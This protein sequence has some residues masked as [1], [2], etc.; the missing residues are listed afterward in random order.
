M[1]KIMVALIMACTFLLTAC[2]GDNGELAGEYQGSKSLSENLKPN[3]WLIEYNKKEDIYTQTLFQSRLN[4]EYFKS[5][6]N[7]G[8]KRNGDWL[9]N[10]KEKHFIK[11]IDKN[12][13]QFRDDDKDI[14][15][16]IK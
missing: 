14:Y 2:G 1:K 10:D 4:G 9:G 16:R 5:V 15:K 13:L 11:V 7:L 6:S 12:T 8:L 3:K